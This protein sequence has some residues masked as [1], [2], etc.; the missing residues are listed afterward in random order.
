[1]IA[2]LGGEAML[3]LRL[4]SRCV[5][6]RAVRGSDHHAVTLLGP[7]ARRRLFGLLDRFSQL[8]Q[9]GHLNRE[10]V[11]NITCRPQFF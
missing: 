6:R 10:G 5:C 3:H 1:M 9:F 7:P 11:G 2:A 4:N 8:E